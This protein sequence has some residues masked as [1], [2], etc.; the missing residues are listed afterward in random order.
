MFDVRRLD[1]VGMSQSCHKAT[2][3]YSATF[4]QLED[5]KAPLLFSTGF[6]SRVSTSEDV[7]WLVHAAIPV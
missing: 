3:A 7:R 2:E 4:L 5:A 1:F 6:L